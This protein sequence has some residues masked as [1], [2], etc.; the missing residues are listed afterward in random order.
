MFAT[1]LS[2]HIC[3]TNVGAKKIDGSKLETYEI[4]ITSFQVDDND[5]KF[6]VFEDTVLL[7]NIG[8]NV[9]FEISFLTLKNIKVSFNNGE[10][11]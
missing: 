9:T 3:K 11:K 8:L 6:C 4:V 5:K 1:R 2:F 10:L 7:A